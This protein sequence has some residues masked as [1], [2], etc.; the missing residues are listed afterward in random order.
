MPSISDSLKLIRK[1]MGLSW[2]KFAVACG[3]SLSM[4]QDYI[5]GKYEPSQRNLRKMSEK[6]GIPKNQLLGDF[7][8]KKI[9]KPRA[10]E[11]LKKKKIRV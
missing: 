2:R 6:L 3:V 4:I 8:I 7:P 9:T 5:S 11:G 10:E 1:E